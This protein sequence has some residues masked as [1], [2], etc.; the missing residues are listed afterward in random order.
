MPDIKFQC[1][2]CNQSL[3]AP[4]DMRGQLID[5]PSCSQ[6]IEVPISHMRPPALHPYYANLPKEPLQK[7][8]MQGQRTPKEKSIPLAIGLNLVLPGIGYMYMGRVILGIF[9]IL[10]IG[11]IYAGTAVMGLFYAWGGLNVI[12]AVDM[13]ILGKKREREIQA[14]TTKVCPKCA[15]TIKRDAR[16]CRYCNADVSRVF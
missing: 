12:M 15:E 7:Y 1:P 5:C 6:P 16:V 10:L 3:E 11:M 9:V 13:I 14:A 2:S 8:P 4:A